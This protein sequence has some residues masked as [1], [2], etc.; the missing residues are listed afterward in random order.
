MKAQRFNICLYLY[1]PRAYIHT[2]TLAPPPPPQG[3]GGGG[4]WEVAPESQQWFRFF[5]STLG[6]SVPTPGRGVCG[7]ECVSVC[8]EYSGSILELGNSRLREIG[9]KPNIRRTCRGFT[10]LKKMSCNFF[11]RGL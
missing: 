7:C 2:L 1:T 11:S 9:A 4:F 6:Q 10:I 8:K 5:S 3:G